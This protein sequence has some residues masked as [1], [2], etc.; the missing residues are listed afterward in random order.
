[1]AVQGRPDQA[2]LQLAID[3]GYFAKQGLDVQTVQI[4]S[5]AQMVPSLATNQ[6][7]VGNG[8]PSAALFNALNRGIDIRLVADYAHVGNEQ[9]TTLALLVRKD[10]LDSGAVKTAADL[11][12]QP[13]GIG[14]IK[15]TVSDLLWDAVLKKEHLNAADFDVSYLPFPDILSALG[16]KR[17]AAGTLT[18]PLA[19]Q[20][21]ATGVA[22]VLYP[23][24]A[25]IPGATLS[26]LQY[27]P[28]FAREQP[29]AATKFMVAYLQGVRDYYDAFHLQKNREDAISLLTKSLSVKD[30]VV[31]QTAGPEFI[32]LN[33]KVNVDDLV[34]QANFYASQGTLEGPVPDIARYV[35]TQFVDAAV[36]TLGAR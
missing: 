3:R 32:D 35:D 34:H 18:E 6:V 21:A 17:L 30:P 2:A 15:G 12:G 26:V 33:G 7:Q 24:G 1:V 11:S 28:A 25:V 36:K 5:G 19:T 4:D 10:L 13:I 23:A 31:W 29:E 9:D 8:A 14:T 16:S 20:A 22:E 27:S